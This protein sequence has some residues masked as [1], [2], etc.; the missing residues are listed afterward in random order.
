ML[1]GTASGYGQSEVQG[2]MSR[3]IRPLPET[4]LSQT[5][6]AP[7]IKVTVLTIAPNGAWGVATEIW[8]GRAIAKA[9]KN[10]KN[11]FSK[12]IGCGYRQTMVWGGW[13]LLRRCGNENILVG[14]KHLA[15]AEQSVA[16]DETMLRT[17][18]VPKMPPCKHVLRV[19]PH[20]TVWLNS[21]STAA[22]MPISVAKTSP[23]LGCSKGEASPSYCGGLLHRHVSAMKVG[24]VERPRFRRSQR[25]NQ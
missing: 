16:A 24:A 9:I 14:E 6:D 10:C 18:Y 3:F 12:K 22:Q 5:R 11:T 23:T 1:G 4:T 13:I 20:G 15:D 19:D 7:E 25:F 2:G 17:L 8:T 21:N